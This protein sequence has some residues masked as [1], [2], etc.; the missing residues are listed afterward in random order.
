[1]MK[2]KMITL[3]RWIVIRTKAKR[4]TCHV[5][6]PRSFDQS[7]TVVFYDRPWLLRRAVDADP[8]AAYR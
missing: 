4:K 3:I 7:F 6:F 2:P 8:S 1:M 5:T